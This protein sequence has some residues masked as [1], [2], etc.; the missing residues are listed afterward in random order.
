M[1]L[2][3]LPPY[4]YSDCCDQAHFLCLNRAFDGSWTI[5]Y[6]DFEEFEA[7]AGLAI[8]NSR[9]IAE[10]VFRMQAAIGRWKRREGGT[11]AV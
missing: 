11:A 9:T 1:S 2:E 8:N 5:A 10:A 3:H 4:L 7:I 6:A